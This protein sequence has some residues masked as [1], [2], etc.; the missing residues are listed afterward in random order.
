MKTKKQISLFAGILLLHYL[1]LTLIQN[2]L[3]PIHFDPKKLFFSDLIGKSLYVPQWLFYILEAG[4]LILLWI[5]SKKIFN[6]YSLITPF[7]YSVSPWSSYLVIAG[8]FYIYLLFFILVGF[9]GLLLLKY[10]NFLGA[11]LI[12]VAILGVGY[13]SLTLLLLI[14][15]VL[16]ITVFKIISFKDLKIF[17]VIITFLLFPLFF[18]IQTHS[19]AFRN[20]LD[21]ET[22]IFSDPGLLNMVNNYQGAAQQEGLGKLAKISENKYLFTV[23]NILLK[24]TKQLVPSN[25]FTPQEKLLNFSFTPPILFGFLIPF[26]YGLYHLIKLPQRKVL[27]LSSLLVIPSVLSRN[28]VDLNR[29]IIF[30]PVVI[31]VISYGL[32]ELIKNKKKKIHNIFLILTLILI[33]LQSLVVISDIQLREKA[34]FTKYYE[35]EQNYEVGKQ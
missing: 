9:Y 20:I 16:L 27:F 3:Y 24:Y 4:N 33:I 1:F 6:K 14:P 30:A 12:S 11:L 2:N 5:I 17:F 34:R 28:M 22:K 29:L 32:I 26:V 8:S 7:V 15:A 21:N 10:K 23:E 35:F 31:I 18:L 13:S 19:V 25:Y